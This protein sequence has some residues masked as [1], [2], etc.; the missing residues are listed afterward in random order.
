MQ[1]ILVACLSPIWVKITDFGISKRWQGTS[2]KTHCGT[3]LYRSP[4]QL[5]LLPRGLKISTKSYTNSIDLWAL[6][7][8]VHEMLT[9]EIPFFD[10]YVDSDPDI[11]TMTST[12]YRAVDM[13]VL[14]GYCR[15][16]IPFPCGSLQNHGVSE[17]GI[18]F[19]K[20]LMVVN[21]SERASAALAVKSPWLVRID[22]PGS[23]L[24]LSAGLPRPSPAT[25]SRDR[26]ERGER[27]GQPGGV[28]VIDP[29]QSPTSGQ[30]SA[31]QGSG[32]DQEA[33]STLTDN[34]PLPPADEAVPDQTRDTI[35]ITDSGDLKT[36]NSTPPATNTKKEK[37]ID[38]GNRQVNAPVVEKAKTI[39]STPPT[40]IS[41]KE[42][43]ISRNPPA[44]TMAKGNEVVNGSI[45]TDL[46]LRPPPPR[47]D[48]ILSE[49]STEGSSRSAHV[50][51]APRTA[52][53]KRPAT[54]KQMQIL[55]TQVRTLNAQAR[56]QNARLS[57]GIRVANKKLKDKET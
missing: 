45:R 54:A 21:P 43:H 33:N 48:M 35:D 12:Q 25:E 22:S 55:T 19:V 49:Q 57:R 37:E 15:G 34:A 14:Y 4:E 39:N 46:Q 7:A 26:K 53:V 40:T 5:G 52:P 17:E 20:S 38:R 41:V 29:F 9:Q 44:P 32:Y 1:N 56:T 50:N 42:K 8:I 2:L 6:G 24:P 23:P 18:E 27:A 3:T 28:L 11:A 13:D 47:A 31:R 16:L 36:I 30:I 51:Q 10:T